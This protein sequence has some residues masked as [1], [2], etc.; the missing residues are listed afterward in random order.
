MASNILFLNQ[1][2]MDQAQLEMLYIMRFHPSQA[3]YQEF[4]R[5]RP[6]KQLE[7]FKKEKDLKQWKNYISYVDMVWN[8]K[9]NKW[10]YLILENQGVLLNALV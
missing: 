7:K 5:Q 3:K 1:L 8:G 9:N 10:A 4:K 2:Q 6:V